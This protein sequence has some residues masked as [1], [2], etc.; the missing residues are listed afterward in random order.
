MNK[1]F[2]AVVAVDTALFLILL[3]SGLMESGHADGGREMGLAFYVILPAIFIGLAVL[4]YVRST[5]VIARWLA[6]VIVAGPGLLIAG[7]RVRD[8]YLRPS[9]SGR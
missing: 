1:V 7:A 6:L 9:R 2:W 3:I 5:S 8:A 4:M